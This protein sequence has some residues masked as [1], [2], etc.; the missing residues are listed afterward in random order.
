MFRWSWSRSRS[1]NKTAA[2]AEVGSPSVLG[3]RQHLGLSKGL[4]QD[5]GPDS[6]RLDMQ[7]GGCCL[8]R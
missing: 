8:P 3:P 2:D 5:R 6:P 1:E 7:Q 4:A